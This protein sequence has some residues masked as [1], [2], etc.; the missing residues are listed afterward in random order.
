[1]VPKKACFSFLGSLLLENSV[2]VPR[3][4]GIN[5]GLGRPCPFVSPSPVG[6]QRRPLSGS[7]REGSPLA[8]CLP[9]TPDLSQSH[10]SEKLTPG[11]CVCP[12]ACMS[13]SRWLAVR[14]ECVG[15]CIVLFASLF[16]VI[17]RHSLSAGLVGLS[18]SY[19]LQV[20]TGAQLCFLILS[21]L[22]RCW[23][24]CFDPPPR[25]S[26]GTGEGPSGVPE[27]QGPAGARGK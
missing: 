4:C 15:N 8:K 19:S 18:V 23:G 5:E 24:L 2:S 20:S 3:G 17:S 14:L 10:I 26:R 11:V 6:G 21:M 22:V 9:P 13:A 7:P 25:R 27:A 12:S 1:M 16:A